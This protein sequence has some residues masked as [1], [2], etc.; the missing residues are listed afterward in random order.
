MDGDSCA[1]RCLALKPSS[2]SNNPDSVGALGAVAIGQSRRQTNVTRKW[3]VL[4]CG[5]N[6]A[7]EKVSNGEALF[8]LSSMKRNLEEL[9]I[10]YLSLNFPPKFPQALQCQL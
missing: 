9:Q 6:V 3:L 10:V 5:G 2:V 7:V 8:L 1:Y 4:Y